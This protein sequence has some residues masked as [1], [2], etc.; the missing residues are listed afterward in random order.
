MV[1][2]NSFS[3]EG[4]LGPL[5]TN[6]IPYLNPKVCIRLPSYMVYRD[7]KITWRTQLRGKLTFRIKP[8]SKN[9]HKKWGFSK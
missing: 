4:L 7:M 3:E 5:S 6:V 2:K 8:K 9:H 1:I